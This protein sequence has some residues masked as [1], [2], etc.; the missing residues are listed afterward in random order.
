MAILTAYSVDY[1][2]NPK[3]Y[4]LKFEIITGSQKEYLAL[5]QLIEALPDV[6]LTSAVVTRYR[7]AMKEAE[8]E[9]E[10]KVGGG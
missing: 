1:D 8:T 5:H 7:D 10:M 2:S 6:G 9:Y 4:K 3:V